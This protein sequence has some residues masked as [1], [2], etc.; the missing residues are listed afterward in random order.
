LGYCHINR[1]CNFRGF[2][3]R[4]AVEFSQDVLVMTR[5][6]F[7]AIALLIVSLMVT[8]SSWDYMKGKSNVAAIR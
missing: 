8:L 5:S 7:L 6:A 2:R 4:P 1:I 3:R